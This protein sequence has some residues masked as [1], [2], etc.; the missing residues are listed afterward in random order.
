MTSATRSSTPTR[1][2]P[3]ALATMQVVSFRLANE[4]YGIEITQVKEIILVG[5]ITRVPQTVPY[6]KGLINLRGTVISIVDLRARFGMVEA[7]YGDDTRIMVMNLAGKTTGIVVDSVS[8]VLR[9][10]TDQVAPTP[11]TV[12]GLGREYLTGLAKLGNRLLI[13]L[14][15]ER[16]L[17]ESVPLEAHKPSAVVA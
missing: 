15:V 2:Q 10:S 14:D 4:E 7:P 8:E 17:T 9:I 13:L 12:T 11:P 6:V 3:D 1:G 5:E 16:L